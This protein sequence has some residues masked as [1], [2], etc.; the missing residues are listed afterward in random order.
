MNLFLSETMNGASSDAPPTDRLTNPHCQTLQLQRTIQLEYLD[1]ERATII[2]D[3]VRA[4][5]SGG[6]GGGG[7]IVV[8]RP[9]AVED[10]FSTTSGGG[11][12]FSFGGGGFSFLSATLE[13]VNDVPTLRV[14]KHTVEIKNDGRAVVVDGQQFPISK[15]KLRIKLTAEGVA[16]LLN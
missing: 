9:S 2:F 6:G 4:P 5:D 10:G 13:Y 7:S 12:G 8:S 1:L 11:G 16:T 15:K 14:G 3:D